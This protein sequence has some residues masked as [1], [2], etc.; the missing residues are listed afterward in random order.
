MTKVYVVMCN[1]YPDAIF[2]TETAAEEYCAAKKAGLALREHS[3][4]GP[5]VHWR[6]YEFELDRR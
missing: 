1:D 6:Y 2:S 3:K 4:Y 5:R